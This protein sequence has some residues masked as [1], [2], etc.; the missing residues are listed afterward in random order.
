MGKSDHRAN[1]LAL[2]RAGLRYAVYGNKLYAL[3]LG[4]SRGESLQGTPS[5]P[6][7]GNR[8][9]AAAFLA[10]E[11]FVGG[12][13]IAIHTN[14]W[15]DSPRSEVARAALH[16]FEWLRDLRHLRSAAARHRAAALT[17]SWLDTFDR[18]APL[19]WR[20]DVTGSRL[21]AWFTN[22]DFLRNSGDVG[23]SDRL[24]RAA[25]RQTRHLTRTAY[26]A[27]AD[28][29]RFAAVK[30]LIHA[31]VYLTGQEAALK[32]GISLL[33][34][35]CS[36]QILPDGCHA[37]R[38]P[39]I[40]LRVLR[41]LIDIRDALITS[42][43]EMPPALQSAIDRMA[44]LL[45]AWRH[46]D[47]RLALFNDSTEEDGT[48]VQTVLALS[49]SRSRALNSAPHTGFQRIAVGRTL[50]LFDGGPPPP[51][52]LDTRAHAGF[53]SFE[54]SVG[55]DRMIVNCGAHGAGDSDWSHALR[56]T[57]AH[58][59]LG[60]DDT[61]TAEVFHGGLGRR[62]AELSCRR[63]DTQGHIMIDA[64]HD[65]YVAAFGLA[66]RRL[67][68]IASNGNDIR[69]EDTLIRT[70]RT[71][72]KANPGRAFAVRFHLHPD[73]RASIADDGDSLLLRLPAGGGWRFRTSK[74]RP[75]LE[76]SIYL[77]TPGSQ[78]R[79]HQIVV[80]GTIGTNGTTVKWRFVKEG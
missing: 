77:G 79:T 2:L 20:P 43:I 28:H 32:Y 72:G 35:E 1:I 62:P 52:G 36:R 38:C 41:D 66:H 44:P 29:R 58:S 7:P 8:E 42:H 27:P 49:G 57:A 11:L 12:S 46:G 5:D 9:A 14:P 69:G 55:K 34:Q 60:V 68:Y 70:G 67:L 39:A 17:L 3:S 18:W 37:Q 48:L 78:R 19:P 73:V 80:R 54:M 21:T 24:V 23:F 16:S 33:N 61:D 65:G 59:C 53:L 51:P 31:G 64:H 50:V 10:G 25:T 47:G 30:G 56:R 6:W 22:F 63:H 75:H 74:G 40:Q 76:D 45:R 15:L 4:S 71:G 13:R 26:D